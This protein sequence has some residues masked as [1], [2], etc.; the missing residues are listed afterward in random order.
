M[1]LRLLP[2]QS[3]G[4]WFRCAVVRIT[5]LPVPYAGCLC[6]FGHLPS[7]VSRPHSPSHSHCQL[8]RVFI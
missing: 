4:V 8:A 7:C 3:S 2:L 6:L 1:A 5:V